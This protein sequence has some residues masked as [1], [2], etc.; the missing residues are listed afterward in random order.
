M[1]LDSCDDVLEPDLDPDPDSPVVAVALPLAEDPADL[2]PVDVGAS[3]M[4]PLAESPVVEESVSDTDD[5]G[6]DD[7]R[8]AV[9][10]KLGMRIESYL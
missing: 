1:V 5:S 7:V 6:A 3:V 2:D 8:D 9:S 10:M 4:V